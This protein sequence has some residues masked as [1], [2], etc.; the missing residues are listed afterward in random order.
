MEVD[1]YDIVT[2]SGT[3][4]KEHIDAQFEPILSQI[5][6]TESQEKILSVFQEVETTWNVRVDQTRKALEATNT[7]LLENTERVPDSTALAVEKTR[8]ELLLE[9]GN[10]EGLCKWMEEMQPYA[11]FKSAGSQIE[12]MIEVI[13]FSAHWLDNVSVR[14]WLVYV[15]SHM[16]VPEKSH[17]PEVIGALKDLRVEVEKRA[18]VRNAPSEDKK[19]YHLANSLLNELEQIKNLSD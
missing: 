18:L 11:F 16:D 9:A 13:G 3:N 5:R 19:I 8:I 2:V 7:S 6:G 12:T 4:S 15:L 10:E 1:L 17:V 14:Q